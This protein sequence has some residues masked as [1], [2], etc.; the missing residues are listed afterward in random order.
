[1]HIGFSVYERT[2]LYKGVIAQS[3]VER[4]RLVAR[5]KFERDVDL[6][7][8]NSRVNMTAGVRSTVNEISDSFRSFSR[9]TNDRT[10]VSI[11]LDR[12]KSFLSFREEITGAQGFSLLYCFI[13]LRAI[14]FVL[15]K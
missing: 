14:H 10:S 12:P 1:M 2:T 4:I 11:A 15:S 5:S 13:E 9:S 3:S 8:S 6:L 7:V